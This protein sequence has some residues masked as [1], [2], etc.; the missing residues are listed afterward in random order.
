MAA[1][2][3]WSEALASLP[4]N[5]RAQLRSGVDNFSDI[6]SEVLV[7]VKEKQTQSLDKRWKFKKISGE[8]IILRDIFEKVVKQLQVFRE[9]G[10]VS[11]QSNSGCAALPWA[12][13]RLLLQISTN[14]T[15]ALG[16]IIEGVEHVTKVISR[17]AIIEAIYLEDC[18]TKA[19][20]ELRNTQITLYA[21]ILKYLVKANDF[22]TSSVRKR[23]VHSMTKP[24]FSGEELLEQIRKHDLQVERAA[25]HMRAEMTSKLH[26]SIS[27][28]AN[29]HE[30]STQRLQTLLHSLEAPIIRMMGSTEYF[31]QSVR[32]EE[33]ARLLRWLSTV[34]CR[35]Q[36]TEIHRHTVPGT[37][38]WLLQ[39][40]DF[41]SW[42]NSSSSQVLW[43]HGIAGCG[44]SILCSMVIRNQL[45]TAAKDSNIA[46]TA[47]FYCSRTI[48][49]AHRTGVAQILS[50]LL[51][52]LC[53]LEATQSIHHSVMT[54][55]RQRSTDADRDG[56]ELSALSLEE[57]KSLLLLITSDF[58]VIIIVDALDELDQN[59]FDVLD[60]LVYIV[61][62]SEN[63]VKILLS[64]R[65]D[66]NI[67]LR[68]DSAVS[69]QISAIN[70][71]QDIQAVVTDR[72]DS[73]VQKR[74]LLAGSVSPDLRESII[75]T[76]TQRSASMFLW[77]CLH[78]E[79][80]CDGSR[81]KLEADVI[82]RLKT[83]PSSLGV[84]ID[85]IYCRIT[86][87]P[88]HARK[89]TKA[90]FAWL[91]AAE[92]PL[93]KTDIETIASQATGTSKHVTASKI[94]DLCSNFIAHDQTSSF[95]AFAHACFPEYLSQL[96]EF[97]QSQIH[98]HVA[99]QCLEHLLVSDLGS[100]HGEDTGVDSGLSSLELLD[101][102]AEIVLPD[103]EESRTD[104]P[105]D[106]SGT[107]SSLDIYRTIFWPR[108]YAKATD[109]PD[110]LA[111][112][113]VLL[114]FVFGNGGALFSAWL[115]DVRNLVQRR[116]ISPPSL[117]KE[118]AAADSQTDSPLML[119]AV[120][121]VQ[122]IF[123]K[124]IALHDRI[125]PDA[126]NSSGA[127]LVYLCAYFGQ[128]AALK[129]LLSQDGSVDIEGG[130][131]GSPIQVA[132]FRGHHDV[133]ECLLDE[134]SDPLKEAKFPTALHAAVAG[135]HEE[136]VQILLRRYTLQMRSHLDD[137][138]V[139]VAYEGQYEAAQMILQQ[140]TSFQDIFEPAGFNHEPL[141]AALYRGRGPRIVKDLLSRLKNVNMSGGHF[142]N[143]MQAACLGGRVDFVRLLLERGADVHAPGRYG[144]PLNAASC[145]GHEAVVRL[146]IE[147]EAVIG[148]ALYSAASKGHL[149]TVKV[150]LPVALASPNEYEREP[151]IH[152]HSALR[153][154]LESASFR[155]HLEIV[156]YLLQ[157]G[158][159][160]AA[161]VAL[162]S[163]LEG[164]QENVAD[165]VFEHVRNHG[166][167]LEDARY[168]D[169]CARWKFMTNCSVPET[170]DQI[171]LVPPRAVT[172]T[173]N[174]TEAAMAS[175]DTSF[176]RQR[177][178][179]SLPAFRGIPAA[180][181][182]REDTPGYHK[183]IPRFIAIN[184]TAQHVESLTSLGF[185]IQT[186]AAECLRYALA[187]GNKEVAEYLT[188]QGVYDEHALSC[189]VVSGRRNM[190]DLVLGNC[191][192]LDPDPP[193]IETE[194]IPSWIPF[195]GES[196]YSSDE[197][198][199]KLSSASPLA[200]SVGWDHIELARSL[201]M[202]KSAI[203]TEPG[204]ALTVAA[205]FGRETYVELI[206]NNIKT[207]F[208]HAESNSIPKVVFDAAQGAIAWSNSGSLQ[209]ILTF[210]RDWQLF[211]NSAM[212]Q[213]LVLAV[214]YGSDEIVH[215]VRDGFQDLDL[216]DVEGAKLLGLARKKRSESEGSHGYS[217][218]DERDI[219]RILSMHGQKPALVPH[220]IEAM[221]KE[222]DNHKT[223]LTEL[224]LEMEPPLQGLSTRTDLL[225]K[226]ISQDFP[227]T[228]FVRLLLRCG[229]N[230][231]STNDAGNTPVY[232]AAILGCS[233]IFLLLIEA[234]ADVK[235]MRGDS[236]GQHA[237]DV[238]DQCA[239][240]RPNLLE[241]T[242]EAFSKEHRAFGSPQAYSNRPGPYY[243]E[244]RTIIFYLVDAG[245]ACDT[246][247]AGFRK[248][249][250]CTMVHNDISS[251]EKSLIYNRKLQQRENPAG[252]QSTF[253]SSTLLRAAQRG[254]GKMV[255]FLVQQDI[256]PI[257][258]N[259]HGKF[260][261]AAAASQHPFQCKVVG[262]QALLEAG[263][264]DSDWSTLLQEA[265]RQGNMSVCQQ[266]LERGIGVTEFPLC[267]SK[268]VL[269]LF[270]RHG[271]SRDIPPGRAAELQRLAVHDEVLEGLTDLD[272]DLTPSTQLV[273]GIQLLASGQ[274]VEYL[275][276]LSVEQMIE[277]S[278][279]LPEK[280]HY[281]NVL[282]V[283]SSKYNLGINDTY[284]CK[285]GI[286]VN[287]RWNMGGYR[288]AEGNRTNLI[289]T[290]CRL[291]DSTGSI[292][293]TTK[294][295]VQFISY[296][297][298]HLANRYIQFARFLLEMGADHNSPGLPCTALY[299]VVRWYK[300]GHH[301]Y[302][303]R[304]RLELARLLLEHGA[305]VNMA[306]KG[307]TDQPLLLFAIANGAKEMVEL[308]L[309]H[310]ADV[311]RGA[312]A[313]L[314]LARWTMIKRD[315]IANLLIEKGAVTREIGPNDVQLL[316]AMLQGCTPWSPEPSFMFEFTECDNCG[317]SKESVSDRPG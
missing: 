144:S 177:S 50:S 83:A 236:G 88:E 129:L 315:D 57:C 167:D 287:D 2:D 4:P 257:D 85:Q 262:W 155:G 215:L 302:V 209:M 15:E 54:E 7:L 201:A 230:V 23:V 261:T 43:L 306:I 202:Q 307:T 186:F 185:Q 61:E 164:A 279:V 195:P 14:E 276:T 21:A 178:E 99:V 266:L 229:V 101:A 139:R 132:A 89:I 62:N 56:L 60:A 76:L 27:V 105:T 171:D 130:Y 222:L 135:G 150:L 208:Q 32:K 16:H 3:L 206:L 313:P 225:F 226:A 113:N 216:I 117:V 140:Q 204:I 228:D 107:I 248:L 95:F 199:R 145:R 300:F 47:Y 263:G 246:S 255:R 172:K 260:I 29:N 131:F 24:E 37:G 254:C 128:V 298:S 147:K 30:A 138:L 66:S 181:K 258:P 111:L 94:E 157:N 231:L 134:G 10:D 290:A 244:W 249:V 192:H 240:T 39:H 299:L 153:Q 146:L 48:E 20:E 220:I 161:K 46:P 122:P 8:V 87:Y 152:Y 203:G 35:R 118:L 293:I 224:V 64:S 316:H 103:A 292:R 176:L 90:V 136:I 207:L 180:I 271:V 286:G 45:E 309:E 221:F 282:A 34:P 314:N 291:I 49:E 182:P 109:N 308:L 285:H 127:P 121:G 31:E 133:V 151:N 160:A 196:E 278:L 198:L 233:E 19:Q 265:A 65:D 68:L 189:A 9:I 247:C 149:S 267:H 115:K 98:C 154:P 317:Q 40:Q 235:R 251:L 218:R 36:H 281:K 42:L 217:Q 227:K 273:K 179:S 93:Y 193:T 33:Q 296:A 294:D 210:A 256:D 100:I 213:L 143:A 239:T 303:D 77:P 197:S 6:L 67:A 5:E 212:I 170:V 288:C 175:K 104:C 26:E 163:A 173:S 137:I 168:E 174:S 59:A 295:S 38:S 188:Q 234:G 183:S 86:Q 194:W 223:R 78:I 245:L 97:S 84:T 232:Y 284:N 80:I 110:Q 12:G 270:A 274:E 51:K 165:F 219:R 305:D 166:L 141:Q 312:I 283:L 28:S 280:Q 125:N 162:E 158:A 22:Y 52:Q 96:E 70:N 81:Y 25:G 191:P 250:E 272:G 79:D 124:S 17:C 142:G 92:R 264:Q 242:L 304:K 123:Q 253:S 205:Q 241:E 13:V 55:Y 275:S 69:I 297:G 114:D 311:N 44:K 211:D 277:A 1:T 41:K 237:S 91:L 252:H 159:S 120:Y 148:W 74:R 53:Y 58:P 108:H 187:A 184:G 126:R 310:G 156:Q 214:E 71:S 169:E 190:V 119:A 269:L 289:H 268:E 301:G 200:M 112:D 72:I 73:A 63:V 259:E 116:G 75:T 11:T 18:V 243:P 102:N 82:D 106:D 238:S